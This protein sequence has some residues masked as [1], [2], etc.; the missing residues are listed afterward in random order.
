MIFKRLLQKESAPQV[1]LM[2]TNLKKKCGI[3][4]RTV[5]E[6]SLHIIHLHDFQFHIQNA[7]VRN[8][9]NSPKPPRPPRS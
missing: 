2:L 5:C 8:L 4:S 3:Y 7:N 6:Q 1:H 9:S